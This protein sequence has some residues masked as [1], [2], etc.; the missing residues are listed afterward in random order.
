M[1]EL[2]DMLGG[3]GAKSGSRSRSTKTGY[4]FWSSKTGA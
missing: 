4:A 2:N 1:G 3:I